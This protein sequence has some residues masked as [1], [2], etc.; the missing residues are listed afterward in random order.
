MVVP[1]QNIEARIEPGMHLL[2]R[3]YAD[4]IADHW[5]KEV[6][7]N[8][9]LFNGEFYLSIGYG[10]KNGRFIVTQRRTCYATFLY[11]YRNKVAM[12]GVANVFSIAA[13]VC[14]DDK[15]IVGQMADHTI[16]GGKLFLPAGSISDDDRVG[17]SLDYEGCMVREVAEETGIVLEAHQGEP[18]YM[19]IEMEGMIAL[20]KRYHL[21]QTSETLIKQIRSNL[22]HLPEQ[23]LTDVC[24][25]SPGELDERMPDFLREFQKFRFLEYK[26]R[27]QAV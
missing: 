22:P 19:M 8:P 7:K 25:F 2:D 21:P 20:I 26:A 16:N 18:C 15:I 3:L 9:H 23:E 24:A 11:W 14:N 27:L 17:T 10:I 4:K 13:M 5:K 6:G 1:I 12:P